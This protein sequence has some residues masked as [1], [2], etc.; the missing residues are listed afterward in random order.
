MPKQKKFTI[1]FTNQECG[2]L[3]DAIYNE[4]DNLKQVREANKYTNV[5]DK[6]NKHISAY[7]K[8]VGKIESCVC[9]GDK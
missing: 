8:L 7:G 6:M 2:Y 9:D 3:L 4:L 5:F 1:E